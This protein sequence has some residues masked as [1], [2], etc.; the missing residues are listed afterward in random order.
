MPLEPTIKLCELKVEDE[1]EATEHL[2]DI[3]FPE[4]GLRLVT[5]LRLDQEDSRLCG[6]LIHSDGIQTSVVLTIKDSLGCDHITAWV[7]DL[8]R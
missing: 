2:V 7:F 5:P 3:G 6:T 1:V 4:V 8:G